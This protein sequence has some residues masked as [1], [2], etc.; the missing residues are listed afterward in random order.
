MRFYEEKLEKE[1]HAENETTNA[2][3]ALAAAKRRYAEAKRK[4]KAVRAHRR[5]FR[6][7]IAFLSREAFNKKSGNHRKI[8]L[9]TI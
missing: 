4:E 9:S 3:L 7:R 1:I 2:R 8:S 6:K 5:R